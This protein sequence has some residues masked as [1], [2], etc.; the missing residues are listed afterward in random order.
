MVRRSCPLILSVTLLATF[1][2]ASCASPPLEFADWTIPVPEGSPIVEYPAVSMEKRSELLELERDL[3][4][5]E[6]F[7]RPLYRPRPVEVGS[8]GR[9]YV[10]DRGNYRVV[11]FDAEGNPLLAFGRQG[12]GPGEFQR[13]DRVAVLDSR[14]VTHDSRLRRLGIFNLDGTHV[15]DRAPLYRLFLSGMRG[16]GERLLL[17]DAVPISGGEGPAP[18][19][20]GS[21]SLDGTRLTS[22]VELAVVGSAYWEKGVWSGSVPLREPWPLG[23]IARDG[24]IYATAGDEYQCLSVDPD[25]NVHWALRV[26]YEPPLLTRSQKRAIVDWQSAQVRQMDPDMTLSDNDFHWPDSH[27]A[28]ENL[29]IDGRGNL[30]VFP[31]SARTPETTF[32]AD[33]PVPVDVYS[34][35]GERLFTGS[36]ALERWDAAFGD[37]LYKRETDPVTEEYVVARYRLVRPF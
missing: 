29:Q 35:A 5:T 18:W 13:L 19:V 33:G 23:A 1:C 22:A 4:V 15:E 16:V 2:L 30:Y 10:P 21:Y 28:I 3:V 34:P 6:A 17:I 20:I 11:V 14:V 12:E 27:A 8:D 36:I 24:T 9:I 25:G 26:A 37:Y 31:H 32:E 7:G